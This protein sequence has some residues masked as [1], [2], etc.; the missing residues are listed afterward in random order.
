MKKSILYNI[1]N[2]W[3]DEDMDDSPIDIDDMEFE[4]S[5]NMDN[6]PDL[7]DDEFV[8]S[9]NVNTNTFFD[10]L[11]NFINKDLFLEDYHVKKDN[12][13]IQGVYVKYT[14]K[15]PLNEHTSK[16]PDFILNKIREFIEKTHYKKNTNRG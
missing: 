15:I 12:K 16:T 7:D 6:E 1:L 5:S 2:E 4:P 13:S 14:Q 9:T 10:D 8:L 3:R 11:V